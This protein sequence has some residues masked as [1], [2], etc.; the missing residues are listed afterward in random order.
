[1]HLLTNSQLQKQNVQQNFNDQFVDQENYKQLRTVAADRV[2]DRLPRTKKTCVWCYY[3][4]KNVH[5]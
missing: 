5:K 3:K 4:T 1:M 2:S